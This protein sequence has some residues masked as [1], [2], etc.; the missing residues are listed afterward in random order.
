M[1]RY[2][3]RVDTCILPDLLVQTKEYHNVCLSRPETCLMSHVCLHLFVQRRVSQQEE[4][5]QAG[6]AVPGS[7]GA[8][9]VSEDGHQNTRALP[10]Q[11]QRCGHS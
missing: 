7:A 11:L 10:L 2:V 3:C 8:D 4:A 9:L 5:K 1:C 6:G